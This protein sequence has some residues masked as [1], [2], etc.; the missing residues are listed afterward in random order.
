MELSHQ[1]HQY[2]EQGEALSS[3]ARTTLKISRWFRHMEVGSFV[4][5]AHRSSCKKHPLNYYLK[6]T[7]HFSTRFRV[8]GLKSLQLFLLRYKYLKI[9]MKAHYVCVLGM[10]TLHV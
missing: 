10:P 9:D 2:H 1:S 5:R 8:E 7:L 6:K 3:K 4:C